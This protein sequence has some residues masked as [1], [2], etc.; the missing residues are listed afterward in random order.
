MHCAISLLFFIVTIVVG[1]DCVVTNRVDCGYVGINQPECEAKGC[2]WKPVNPNPGNE[3][4]C[5]YQHGKDPCG[6]L[7]FTSSGIPFSTNEINTMM[8]YFLANINIDGKGG[9]VASPDTMVPSGG[10]YYFHWERDG[11]LSMRALEQ[12]S[13]YVYAAPFMANYVQWVLKVQNEQ[14]PNGIDVRTEPK[15][16]LPN[17]DVYS[18]GWCRP[19]TDGPGLRGLTLIIHARNLLKHGGDAY[20]KQYL[21]TGS[22][23]YNGGAIK[24]DL[25]WVADNWQQNGCDLWE[26]IR[27]TDLFW[28]RF[29]FM[30]AMFE[31]AKFAQTLGDSAS[32]ARYQ[33]TLAAIQAV[34]M[35]HFNGDY[36][37][38]SSNRQQDAAVTSAFVEGYY[39]QEFGPTSMEVAKTISTFNSLFCNSFLINQKDNQNHVPG[40]LYGRYQGDSYAGGNPWILTTASLAE[41]FYQGASHTIRAAALPEPEAFTVW[42]SILNI[43]TKTTVSHRDFARLLLSAGDSVLNRIAYHVKGDNFHLYEQID[44]NTGY[45][46]SATDLTWSY[47][48]V[49]KAMFVRNQTATLIN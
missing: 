26:E 48:N 23:S 47:A 30:R 3:P 40:V 44:R 8:D 19:Q 4:W 38:E 6:K 16:N 7:N 10:S 34:I 9:V 31:G 33:Q 42:R 5:F 21:W 37:F 28:N 27:S 18:G 17:G 49:L 35:E 20:V 41:L 32:A 43:P 22:S 11:A 29:N 2:C 13:P 39:G 1:Q 25:D 24:Y 12:I 15:Y 36:V 45:Q 14:D 46:R